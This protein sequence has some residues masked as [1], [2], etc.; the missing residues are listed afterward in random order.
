MTLSGLRIFL[1]TIAKILLLLLR[2]VLGSGY[3]DYV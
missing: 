1:S 2:E 3:L